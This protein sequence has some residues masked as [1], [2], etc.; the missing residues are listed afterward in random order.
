M[1]HAAV[2]GLTAVLN[3]NLFEHEA[4]WTA[5]CDF[6]LATPATRVHWIEIFTICLDARLAGYLKKIPARLSG[7]Q[8]MSATKVK[9]ILFVH[10]IILCFN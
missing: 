4:S 7:Y 1:N 5:V 9:C 8:L 3:S 6:R 2:D 10:I